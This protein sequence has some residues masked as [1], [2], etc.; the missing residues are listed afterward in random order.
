M[1]V[2]GETLIWHLAR[3]YEE[4]T[5]GGFKKKKVKERIAAMA[6]NSE[7]PWNVRKPELITQWGSSNVKCSLGSGRFPKGTWGWG[8]GRFFGGFHEAVSGR[9]SWPEGMAGPVMWLQG[10]E[11]M[12]LPT[13]YYGSCGCAQPDSKALAE[14]TGSWLTPANSTSGN[15]Q[16]C[17]QVLDSRTLRLTNEYTHVPC[18]PIKTQNIPI[19]PNISL[20]PLPSQ[21]P[22]IYSSTHN[23][24]QLLI[25][26]LSLAD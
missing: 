19:T 17:S 18:T 23:T 14:N 20:M 22:S 2:S 5:N 11:E 13:C 26:F 1:L 16:P 4:N 7:Q 10:R 8:K 15:R 12:A 6:Q 24:K 9:G 21:C 3:K 25:L